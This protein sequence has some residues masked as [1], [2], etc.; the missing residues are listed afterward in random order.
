MATASSP[1]IASIRLLSPQLQVAALESVL[2]DASRAEREAFASMLL[3][4]ALPSPFDGTEPAVPFIVRVL[5]SIRIQ[6]TRGELSERARVAMVR[7]WTV[8][9]ESIRA[10]ARAIPTPLWQVP[11][12]EASTS[13]DP[14]SRRGAAAFARD[15]GADAEP[16]VGLLYDPVSAVVEASEAA[17]VARV[18]AEGLPESGEGED[19]LSE[20]VASVAQAAS[21][22][23]THK[24]PGIVL[25]AMILATRSRL[26]MEGDPLSAWYRRETKLSGGASRGLLRSGKA[27]IF[28]LRAWE[29]LAHSE[30][31]SASQTRLSDSE[32]IDDYEQVLRAWHLI[33][34][35]ARGTRAQ[36]IAHSNE[37]RLL[38]TGGELNQLSAESRWGALRMASEAGASVKVR[39]EL[40]GAVLADGDV[41]VRLSAANG[42]PASALPD[43]QFDPDARVARRALLRLSEVGEVARFASGRAGGRQASSVGSVA[44]RLGAL[45]RVRDVLL[46]S[47]ATQ[48]LHRMEIVARAGLTRS[49]QGSRSEAAGV[50]ARSIEVG[51]SEEAMT[52]LGV[53]R[54][55]GVIDDIAGAVESRIRAGGDSRLTASCVAALGESTRARTVE[56]LAAVLGHEEARV[57]A[58]AV[59]AMAR[60]AARSGGQMPMSRVFE[61]KGDANHRVQANVLRAA[62]VSGFEVER[63]WDAMHSMLVSGASPV[64]LAGTWLASR[65]LPGRWTLGSAKRWEASAH[66]LVEMA[67][68]DDHAGVRDRAAALIELLNLEGRGAASAAGLAEFSPE[69]WGVTS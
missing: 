43:F 18:I 7:R 39:A 30:W 59:E 63:S 48:D 19:G 41:L 33:L 47:W 37:S 17:I 1:A 56:I 28:R 55:A 50:L 12:V 22:F 11:V 29:W 24:R 49:V 10:A 21:A 66:C 34:H 64:R 6:P 2:G 27:G 57:R 8:L 58:N 9:P 61:L 31:V 20:L 13:Q 53:A 54:R 16:I 4:L 52:A 35:P 15:M 5:S 3:E 65:V 40:T 25:G 69:R 68:K 26:R 36:A 67:T 62:I 51:S 60:A 32:T 44:G 23:G 14:L 46:A 42:A 45:R 38:P